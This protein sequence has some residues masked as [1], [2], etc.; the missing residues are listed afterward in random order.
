MKSLNLDQGSTQK[1]SE[2]VN[3]PAL[4]AR[5][6]TSYDSTSGRLWTILSD[7]WDPESNQEGY[8]T[9][10][11]ADNALLQNDI[12]QRINE[13]SDVPKHILT[14]NNGP[15]G[16]FRSKAAISRF[17]S[18]QLNTFKAIDVADVVVTNGV[19]SAM[20]HCSWAIC[21]PGDGVLLGRPYYPGFLGD[22][23]LRPNVRVVPVSFD[24]K[25]PLDVSSVAAYERAL[26]T[27]SEQGV[28]IKAVMLCNPHNPLGRCYSRGFLMQLMKLCQ[29][30]SIH[31]ISDEI[32]AL[33]VWRHGSNDTQSMQ[34][35]TSVLSINHTNILDPALLHVLW[36]TSK[37]FGTNG[38]RCGV[39]ISRNHDLIECLSNVGIFSFAS[40]LTDH[41]VSEILEDDQFTDTYISSNRKA[42]LD[43]YE[44]VAKTLEGMGVPYATTSNAALFI[45]C[46]LL[47][48][49]LQRQSVVPYAVR[50]PDELWLASG[51][52]A[53]K[54]NNARVHVGVP[55]QFGSELPGWFRLTISRPRAQLEEGLRRI[56]RVLKNS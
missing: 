2:A 41:V 46:D 56:D 36:G 4:S 10:G 53:Q 47:T 26:L 11:V 29:K 8:I 13:C 22:L 32:Y 44:F 37:D 14:Y 50:E 23:G 48:P 30:Y 33:S 31:L 28:K 15:S 6:A 54:L 42:L 45:W 1:P 20:E 55:D 34:P 24:A 52:L 12:V 18:R 9:L 51:N 25:D 3:I 7:L 17:L 39:I 19:A 40:G 43:A 16:S 5:A 35:F 21:D 38:L 27:S 49:F